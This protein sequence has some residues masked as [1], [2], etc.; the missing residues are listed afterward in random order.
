VT[1]LELE[2]EPTLPPAIASKLAGLRAQLRRT[3][4]LRGLARV[5]LVL[6]AF[7]VGTLVLDVLLD[8]PTAFRLVL[9]AG[10]VAA[11]GWAAV[12]LLVRPLARVADDD[13]VALRVE[14]E[15]PDLR[16]ELI[17]A[18]QLSRLRPEQRAYQSTALVREVI[19]GAAT[20]AGGLDFARV[21][22]REHGRRALFALFAAALCA[23][24][25]FLSN[26]DLARIWIDRM[27]F[28]GDTPW[29][30]SVD[31]AVATQPTPAVVAR[32]DDLVVTAE[33]KRGAPSRVSI[34]PTFEKTG[35]GDD[36]PMVQMHDGFRAVFENV[37]EPFS[38]VVEGGDYKSQ[39]FRVEVRQRP[40]VED[41]Q[42]FVEYPA[43]TGLAAPA[44]PQKDGNLKVP[45]GTRV[46]YEARA[47]EP[48]KLAAVT[49]ASEAAVDVAKPATLGGERDRTIAGEFVVKDSTAWSF[50]LVSKE[51]FESP[52]AAQY[53]IRAIP[54]RL[55]D[56]K[57]LRPGRNK[58]VTKDAV[59]PLKIEVKDDYQPQGAAL[60]AA[61][62]A[63]AASGA[64]PAAA[65]AARPE[66][67]SRR[68]PLP[69]LP[70]EEKGEKQVTIAYDL[71][72]ADMNL[73]P[74]DVLTYWAEAVDNRAPSPDTTSVG[75]ENRGKSEKY[76]LRVVPA[77]EFQ[78]QLQARLKRLRD[79]LL[80]TSKSQKATRD[81]LESLAGELAAHAP[82]ALDPKDRRRLTYA[83]LDQRKIGQRIERARDEFADVRDEMASNKVG[84][85]EDLQWLAELEAMAQDLAKERAARASGLLQE[86]RQAEKPAAAPLGEIVK[87]ESQVMDGLDEIVRRLDK[88]DEFNEV[89]RDIRDLL[90]LEERIKSETQERAK[91]DLNEPQPR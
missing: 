28:L 72:L 12:R 87:L 41:L 43:Y 17:S 78:R 89:L 20:R 37:N 66:G 77:D 14:R 91:R 57:I 90:Q 42:V 32:G 34:R 44:G 18:V 59:V 21:A 71:A 25:P 64:P 30:R 67:E 26:P 50:R 24:L 55:P 45:A 13:A 40:K 69:G 29:P 47:S 23:S 73:Q 83:E 86:L 5:A 68:I 33:V 76:Q 75:P 8:L 58:D 31:L 70:P 19:A 46:R 84:K 35:R 53:T 74:N 80:Q 27:L 85:P 6:A 11:L 81:D 82:A 79:D 9:L 51:S 88:W 22:G 54:D 4:L 16:D 49:F 39:R 36:V 63:R 62:G 48:L 10:G 56:V 2:T 7:V 65:G 3:T 1:P 52:Q 15:F 38:F 61:L 60:V